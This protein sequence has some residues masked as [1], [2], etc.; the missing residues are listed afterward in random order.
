MFKSDQGFNSKTVID[1]FRHQCFKSLRQACSNA[2]ANNSS[3][4]PN[5]STTNMNNEEASYRYESL[6]VLLVDIK[7]TSM[8]LMSA[9]CRYSNQ[10]PAIEIPNLLYDMMSLNMVYR[11]DPGHNLNGQ[12]DASKSAVANE[13]IN[14]EQRNVDV[15]IAGEEEADEEEDEEEDEDDNSDDVDED[16]KEMIDE[17]NPL[18]GGDDE[19]VKEEERRRHSNGNMSD[20]EMI[21]T[22]SK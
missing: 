6:L 8:K 3:I 11:F 7:S 14:E 15:K 19:V 22:S 21:S 10:S 5:E 4:Q 16:S 2:A 20:Q 13:I 9:I 18:G 12:L 17:E 1:L